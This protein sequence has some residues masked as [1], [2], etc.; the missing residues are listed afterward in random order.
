[1][2]IGRSRAETRL[3]LLEVAAM[4]SEFHGWLADDLGDTAEGRRRSEQALQFAEA[5]GN[6]NLSAYILMRMSQQAQ[7][8]GD[9]G[10]V[11]P[12]AAAAM[13]RGPSGRVTGRV[14]AATAQQRAF[15]YA[16]DRNEGKALDSWDHACRII[17][18]TRETEDDPFHLADYCSTP[19]L[20]AQRGLILAT[21]G[22]YE[23]ALD[24]YTDAL[25][26]WPSE[27]RR[28][29][30]LQFARQAQIAVSAG[31][32]DRALSSVTSAMRIERETH[33][34]RIMRLVDIVLD[35]MPNTKDVQELREMTTR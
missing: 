8:S 33:S 24:A 20:M 22:R 3:R 1:K 21:L 16:L 10:M 13:R 5:S 27:Y 2:L 18:D 35:A 14:L 25:V 4:F 12:L 6:E 32:I 29:H 31:H 28:E 15:G 7:L 23:E 9:R 34:R 11:E 17:T 19:Y 30:G 26:S